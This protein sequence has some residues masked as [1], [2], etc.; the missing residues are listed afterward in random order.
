MKTVRAF[1]FPREPIVFLKILSR[2]GDQRVRVRTRIEF[3]TPEDMNN[4]F[5]EIWWGEP[6]VSQIRVLSNNG[7]HYALYAKD[8]FLAARALRVLWLVCW[9]FRPEG[10]MATGWSGG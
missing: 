9:T 10:W 5:D 7:F 4:L 3:D 8:N 6:N 1:P 2:G